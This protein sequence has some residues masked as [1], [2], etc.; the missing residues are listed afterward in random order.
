MPELVTHFIDGREV[1]SQDERTFDS[2]SP[3]TGEVL[4][5][6]SFGGPGDVDRA[7]RAAG[8]AF[9]GGGWRDMPPAARGAVLRRLAGLIADNADRI[10]LTEARDA[11]KPIT[12]ARY[13]ALSSRPGSG[14]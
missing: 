6:V 9:E 1:P 4:A 7:A 12:Q 14:R 13:E 8:K 5:H 11:G 2:V 10:A 3:A